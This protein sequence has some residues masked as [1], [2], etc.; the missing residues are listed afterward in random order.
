[1]IYFN[2]NKK[3]DKQYKYFIEPC[4]KID[5]GASNQ[6]R[7]RGVQPAATTACLGGGKSGEGGGGGSGVGGGGGDGS[8]TDRCSD[9]VAGLRRWW[10]RVSGGGGGFVVKMSL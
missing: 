9:G 10:W 2:R 4:N 3:K 7:L 1:M 6:Q 5:E 8:R